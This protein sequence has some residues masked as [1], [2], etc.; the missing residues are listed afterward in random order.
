MELYMEIA[1]AYVELGYPD[2]AV[3]AAYK[4]LLLVD[5][6]TD[7]S[8]EYYED[9]YDTV[10]ETIQRQ[11]VPLRLSM[12]QYHPK[13]KERFNPYTLPLDEEGYRILPEVQDDEIE[14]WIKEWYTPTV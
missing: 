7:E 8:D 12:I 3:G 9:A 13:I 14:V 10:L 11:P 2:L 5:A 6:A 4:A 1:R